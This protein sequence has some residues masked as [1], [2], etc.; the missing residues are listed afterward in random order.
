MP[1]N[2]SE[3]GFG[4][5]A[6]YNLPYLRRYARALTGNQTVGDD[7]AA[8]TLET[9]LADPRHFEA[10]NDGRVALFR[11]FH[12]IWTAVGSVVENRED[13][14]KARAQQHLSLLEPLSREALLLTTMEEFTYVDAGQILDLTPH[15]VERLVQMARRQMHEAVTGTV[16]II[17][18]EAIIAMDLEAMVVDMGHRIAGV[19]RTRDAATALGRSTPPDLI[20]TDIKLADNSSGI[21]AVLDLIELIGSRPV[22]CITAYPERLLTGCK[23]E[24]AFLITKPYTEAQVRSAISQAM[25]FASTE[26]LGAAARANL[27]RN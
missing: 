27:P 23:P 3:R 12:Q 14:L 21:D 4:T 10:Q 7:L 19:A 20:L 15:E 6:E 26:T 9:V 24:P 2:K 11:V 17:E 8:S 5:V 18:D 13:G 1:I 22:V 16:L 25:F